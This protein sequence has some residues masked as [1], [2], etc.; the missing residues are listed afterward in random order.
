M[1]V[2]GKLGFCVNN[3][4][5]TRQKSPN[6]FW[7]LLQRCVLFKPGLGNGGIVGAERRSGTGEK[8]MGQQ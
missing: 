8:A 1:R 3:R 4:I 2:H 7:G 6:T 5:V